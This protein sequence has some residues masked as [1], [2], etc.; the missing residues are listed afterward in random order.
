MGA[1]TT[2][3]VGLKSTFHWTPDRVMTPWRNL[4]RNERRKEV[5]ILIRDFAGQVD[6]P[7]ASRILGKRSGLELETFWDLPMLPKPETIAV[8]I[9]ISAVKLDSLS[10]E[11]NPAKIFPARAKADSFSGFLHTKQAFIGDR[12][13]RL[14]VDFKKL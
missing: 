11:R 5:S 14:G 10:I 12:L 2:A 7:A 9:N 13:N 3:T 8:L 4:N 6:K 1:P